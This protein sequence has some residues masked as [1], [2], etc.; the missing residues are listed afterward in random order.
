MIFGDQELMLYLTGGI[1]AVS[2]IWLAVR[3]WRGK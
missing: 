1:L 3:A 2:F